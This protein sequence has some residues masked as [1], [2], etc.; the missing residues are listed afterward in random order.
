MLVMDISCIAHPRPG[1]GSVREFCTAKTK[2]KNGAQT[3]Q[4]GFEL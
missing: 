2:K 1:I 3:Q 4:S